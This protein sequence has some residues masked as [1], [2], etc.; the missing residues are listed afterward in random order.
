MSNNTQRKKLLRA[1]ARR[2]LSEFEGRP[3]GENDIERDAQG[4]PFF[5]GSEA[6][7][8]ISHSANLTAI[9]YVTG[10]KPR[11]SRTGCDVELIRPRGGIREI[12]E[13]YF[14]Q[15]ERD[16]IFSRSEFEIKRFYE[17][18]TLKECFLKL[19]GLS[20]FDMPSAPSFSDGETLNSLSLGAAFIRVEGFNTT[21]FRALKKC[22][23]PR[24]QIP[25]K[26]NIPRPF[27]AGLLIY[28]VLFCL[29]EISDGADE[30]YIL[31]TALEGTEQERP[32]IRM[33][34]HLSLT[35]KKIAEIKAAPNP[36]ETVRPK[37]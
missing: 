27:R 30:R 9:S 17:I 20:V 3:I 32:E 33:F 1:E 21:P 18:W 23:K 15:G 11:P 36:A 31:A 13:S 2:I 34:S 19:K 22:I 16:Y 12:A 29:Y 7:F 25:Y 14:S 8:N 26:N 28:P 6:D 10:A 37:M 5:Q 24:I 35:C 4:R